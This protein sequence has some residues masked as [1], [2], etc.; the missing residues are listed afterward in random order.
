MNPN[1]E[2]QLIE[3]DSSK[4]KTEPKPAK[5]VLPFLLQTIAV[6]GLIYFF[7]LTALVI[8]SFIYIDGLHQ[9]L[10]DYLSNFDLSVKV[11]KLIMIPFI[12]LLLANI[13]G[14]I[15]ILFKRKIGIIMFSTGSFITFMLI[16][17]FIKF[18]WIYSGFVL[19]FVCLPLLYLRKLK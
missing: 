1:E 16:L 8:F 11:L 3:N 5:Q 14:A 17:I 19:L 15:I 13:T 2:N 7:V 18:N 9:Y 10:A 12:L 6:S 4:V